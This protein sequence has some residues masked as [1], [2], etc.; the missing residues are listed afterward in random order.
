MDKSIH[1]TIPNRVGT[2]KQY[3]SIK[4]QLNFVLYII[5]YRNIVDV[6]K[7]LILCT[8]QLHIPDFGSVSCQFWCR[9]QNFSNHICGTTKSRRL[10]KWWNHSLCGMATCWQ[11][12]IFIANKTKENSRIGHWNPSYPI[13]NL[14]NRVEI[15]NIGDKSREY[16]E[17]GQD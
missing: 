3:F 14:S 11:T 5:Y 17:F 1:N 9:D 12:I 4:I 6:I 2:E 13:N 16:S 8:L 15:V 7:Y 10:G